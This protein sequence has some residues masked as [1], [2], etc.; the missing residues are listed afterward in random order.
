MNTKEWPHQVQAR[1]ALRQSTERTMQLAREVAKCR[2]CNGPMAD[3][4]AIQQTYTSGL[5]DFPGDEIGRGCTV[6]PGGPGKLI[7]CKK[8]TQCGWSVT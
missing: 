6:S 1:E 8:C 2:K 3:S 4:T 5:P 7:D